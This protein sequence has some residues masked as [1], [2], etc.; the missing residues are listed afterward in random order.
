M[1]HFKSIIATTIFTTLHGMAMAQDTDDSLAIQRKKYVRELQPIEI[2][3]L[4]ASA[5]APFA[6]TD[7]SGKEIEQQN[8]GQDLPILLQQTVSTVVTSDAGAGVGYT[9]MRVRG[10]D[11]TRINV[12]L[13]G[14]PVNDAESQGSYFVD[15]PDLASSTSSIQ[16]QRGVGTST[17]GAGA[18]GATLSVSNME[19]MQ[20]AGAEV[21]I[22]AASFNTQKYTLKAGTGLLDNGWSFDVR[23]SKI[24]SDG[25]IQRSASDLKSLQ[26]LT[27]WQINEK[28]KFR[29]QVLSGTE[30]TGQAWDGVPQDSLATNRRYNELGLK[31]NGTYYS[32]QT[33]NYVQTYYQAFL[34]HNFN[35]HWSGHVGLFLT[36]GKG[37]Y[38]EYKQ[39]QNFSDYGLPNFT[40]TSDT[41]RTTDMIR[42][43]WLDNYYYGGVYSVDYTR[44]NTLVTFG[45]AITQYTGTHYGI[46]KWAEYGVPDNYKWY[47]NDAQKND[48]SNYIKLQQTINKHLTL[49]ADLQLRTVSYF[50]NG[51]E[52]NLTL[53]PAVNYNFLNP[54]LGANYMLHN[55]QYNKQRIYASVAMASKEPNRDDFQASP[56]QLPKPEKL[57]DIEAGYEINRKKWSASANV[58]YMDYKDQLVLTGQINDVGAY[59]RTNVD[60]SYRAGIELQGSY[61]AKKWLQLNGN[62]SL[63]KNKIKSFT[64][65]IDNWDNGGQDAVAHKNTDIAFSPDV[66]AALDIKLLPFQH[67]FKLYPGQHVELDFLGKHVGR[68]YLDNTSNKARSIA[69]YSLL[70]FRARY[71]LQIKHGR[72]LSLTFAINNILNRK[73]ESNGYNYSYINGGNLTTS[74][75]YFPQAGTNIWGGIGLKF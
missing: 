11:A 74:N 41:L 38:E 14:I 65:Y 71:V 21:N 2:R 6:K 70:D 63:S 64:E 27:S 68:Q 47:T 73:Y 31:S 8:L 48:W 56:T 5:N 19:Q 29:F 53:R 75:Y 62:V 57:T 44:H 3:S 72:E 49:Y 28:T 18:F 43:L 69:D 54:K 40:T 30:K 34:D 67:F 16:L 25:Y 22:S 33:D 39:G 50:M 46:I 32:N 26:V 24:S 58:F 45:G 17:N 9:G 4:R 36:R 13:N 51:F 61:K 37:Y 15:L 66:V 23:L 35:A 7:I 20:Q 12:T 42:Q 59:T 60:K 10:S 52:E 1:A 55:E